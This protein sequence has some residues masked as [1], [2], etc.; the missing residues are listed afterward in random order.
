MQELAVAA[1]NRRTRLVVTWLFVV[2]V[3]LLL[4]CSCAVH[5]RSPLLL[6]PYRYVSLPLACFFSLI[7]P[8]DLGVLLDDNIYRVMW[9]AA[10]EDGDTRRV[11]AAAGFATASR[12]GTPKRKHPINNRLR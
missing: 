1:M 12:Y 5:V 11:L 8:W 10:D 4:L 3:L 9:N 7:F 6:A 2:V